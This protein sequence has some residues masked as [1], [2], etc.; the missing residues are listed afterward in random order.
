MKQ[1]SRELRNRK[2]EAYDPQK[3]FNHWVEEYAYTHEMSIEEV[4]NLSIFKDNGM[5]YTGGGE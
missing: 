4:L 2:A 3:A 1:L 5:E